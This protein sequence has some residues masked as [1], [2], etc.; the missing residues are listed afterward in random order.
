METLNTIILK[1]SFHVVATVLFYVVIFLLLL[2]TVANT[3]VRRNSDIANVFGSGFYSVQSDS[4][5]GG[6]NISFIS[7]DIALVKMLDESLID[8]LEVGDV[9][10]YYDKTANRLVSNPI[11][12][13]Y[14]VDETLYFTTQGDQALETD[15]PIEADS[16]LG[17]YQSSITGLGG[18]LDYLQSPEGFALLVIFP[19]I[20]IL[21]FESVRLY[22]NLSNYS[23]LRSEARVKKTYKKILKN[24]ES[25][26]NRIRHQVMSNWITEIDYEKIVKLRI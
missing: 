12:D 19:V 6:Y 23:K 9:V 20:V 15:E 5:L 1:K 2:F 13:I 18:F 8:E 22:N 10:T 14:S 4:I 17:V 16:V 3:N 7:R 11:V 21:L 26:T 24:L 25:E